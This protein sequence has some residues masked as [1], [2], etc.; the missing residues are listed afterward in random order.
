MSFSIQTTF[1]YHAQ[2]NI[3]ICLGKFETFLANGRPV[4]LGKTHKSI[5]QRI[6][7]NGRYGGWGFWE[8]T[9]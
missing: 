2:S 6:T 5:F 1:L 3:L 4:G 9:L 8:W 7:S